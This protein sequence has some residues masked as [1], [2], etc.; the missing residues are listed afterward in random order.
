MTHLSIAGGPWSRLPDVI[1]EKLQLS[2]K[3]RKLF[4]GDL[5]H[6]INSYPVFGATEAQYLRCQIARIS[7]ATVVSPAGYYIPDP[8]EAENEGSMRFIY[9]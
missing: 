8:E 7:A 3:I 6:K 4:T 2:R 1:P 5:S 9:F